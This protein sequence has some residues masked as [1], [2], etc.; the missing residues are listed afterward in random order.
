MRIIKFFIFLLNTLDKSVRNLSEKYGDR[1]SRPKLPSPYR[2]ILRLS[3]SSSSSASQR[4]K[5]SSR[6]SEPLLM[7]L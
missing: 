3:C 7:E 6:G 1:N 2:P 4:L 5:L